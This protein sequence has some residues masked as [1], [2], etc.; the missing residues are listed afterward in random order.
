MMSR[1]PDHGQ[2]RCT[3]CL[4]L[5]ALLAACASPKTDTADT[6]A[7][8]EAPLE[9]QEV[10]DTREDYDDRAW[11]CELETLCDHVR[12]DAGEQAFD[13]RAAAQCLLQALV[14]RE[15]GALTLG[16]QD[17]DITSSRSST[18]LIL[19]TAG[20]VAENN[21]GYQDMVTYYYVR[22]PY[23]LKSAAYFEGCLEAG[24]DEQ[25]ADCLFAWR[26]GDCVELE[27]TC[28]GGF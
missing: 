16:Y 9:C 15:P 26:D 17:S 5:A 27:T 21:I 8:P 2:H 24:S 19:D 20:H 28:G 12:Y 23:R 4:L 14:D 13:S 1:L 18:L 25:M 7:G 11:D 10:L 3:G 22:R 6:A